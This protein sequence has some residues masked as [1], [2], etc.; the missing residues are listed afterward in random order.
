M[1]VAKTTTPHTNLTQQQN[2][3]WR[4]KK[5]T[6]RNDFFFRSFLFTW[7]GDSV[8]VVVVI[9][10]RLSSCSIWAW[11]C[12]GEY[13]W[14]TKWI[15]FITWRCLW[16]TTTERFVRNDFIVWQ[17]QDV[18]CLNIPTYTI[19]HGRFFPDITNQMILHFVNCTKVF[20]VIVNVS[21]KLVIYTRSQFIQ[22]HLKKM[23]R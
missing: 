20:L 4:K 21:C 1:N 5:K 10:L 8:V 11:I 3:N 13:S 16:H 2:T 18:R 15:K 14:R 23:I 12:D 22:K 6:R 19:K 9:L 17:S 7:S